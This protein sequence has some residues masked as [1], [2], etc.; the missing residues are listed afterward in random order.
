[1][2]SI[3]YSLTAPVRKNHNDNIY[4]LVGAKGFEPESNPEVS[5]KH[6]CTCEN[7]PYPRAAN[8]L[9]SGNSNGHSLATI[10][11]DLQSIIEAWKDLPSHIRMSILTLTK[12]R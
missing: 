9:H 5:I 11:P 6:V 4:L 2:S 7:C 8:A 12:L 3:R 10:D 1:M